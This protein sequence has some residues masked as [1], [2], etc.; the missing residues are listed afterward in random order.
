MSIRVELSPI[1]AQHT[2]NQ[3]VIQAKGSTV[4]E[5]L[6]HLVKRFPDL[7]SAFFDKNGRLYRYIDIYVNGESA[8]PEELTKP[9]KN[10]DKLN[11]LILVAGG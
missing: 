9:V 3:L 10:G 11:I 2:N 8:Y 5:C 1:F 6:D 7:K 4:G